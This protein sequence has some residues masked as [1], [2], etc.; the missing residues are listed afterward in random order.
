MITKLIRLLPDER[1]RAFQN[2]YFFRLG[3]ITA[4]VLA[5][6]VVIH[7][8]LLAPAYFNLQQSKSLEQSRLDAIAQRLASSGDQEIVGR[9]SMLGSET[10]HLAKIGGTPSAAASVRSILT[11]PRSGIS[12][13]GFSFTPPAGKAVGQMRVTG[14][15]V[16]R[17]SLRRYQSTLA[18]LPGVSG[19]DLPISSYAKE[20]DI[21]FTITLSGTF[22]PTP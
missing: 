6:L 14:T 16:S 17:D 2:D 7:G 10:E 18:T 15:A 21:P 5:V 19:A 3:T 9:L 20:S 12:L 11:L 13:T 4:L 22:A 8:I 1:R